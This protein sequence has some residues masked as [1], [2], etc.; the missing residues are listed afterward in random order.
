MA[1]GVAAGLDWS[2]MAE[3]EVTD[4]VCMSEVKS[5]RAPDGGVNYGKRMLAQEGSRRREDGS[6]WWS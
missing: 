2:A 5:I 4:S 3:T 6:V 1:V